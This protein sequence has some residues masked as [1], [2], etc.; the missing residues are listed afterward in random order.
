MSFFNTPTPVCTCYST[1]RWTTFHYIYS[2]WEP[3]ESFQWNS[4]SIKNFSYTNF[5]PA[6]NNANMSH[7]YVNF[8]C[9]CIFFKLFPYCNCFG[10]LNTANCD[11]R[12]R[13][14]TFCTFHCAE[15]VA[16]RLEDFITYEP[17]FSHGG[18]NYYCH[19]GF[20]SFIQNYSC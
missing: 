20:P 15:G 8:I 12:P 16:V 9:F 19:C 4:T 14:R 17:D 13:S 3:V 10:A 2:P 5:N 18:I 1:F 11:Y 7:T 6:R